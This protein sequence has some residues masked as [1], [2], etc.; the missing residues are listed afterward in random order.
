MVKYGVKVVGGTDKTLLKSLFSCLF[1]MLDFLGIWIFV[2]RRFVGQQRIGGGMVS[3]GKSKAKIFVVSGTYVTF[4]DVAGV[5]EAKVELQEIVAFLKNPDTYGR[6]GARMPIGVILVGLPGTGK[7]LL[8]RAV[9]V[10]AGV[11]FFRSVAPS[12]WRCSSAS[13]PPAS[14]TCSN[15]PANQCPKFVIDE[16]DALGWARDGSPGMGEHDEK[17]QT[18]NQ[19]L[20][21]LDDF[22][23]LKASLVLLTV[24]NRLLNPMENESP[25]GSRDGP[26]AG[27]VGLTGQ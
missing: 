4:D 27:S 20:M 2:I 22:D 9:A 6:L 23:P 14:M 24:T 12:S 26:R 11:P 25:H 8:V 21:D 16:L 13:V 15:K 7:S 17:E 19:L 1:S 3:I 5:D 18:L 10:E